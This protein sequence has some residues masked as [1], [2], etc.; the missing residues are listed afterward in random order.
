MPSHLA[1]AAVHSVP[2][3]VMLLLSNAWPYHPG[4][5]HY[6]PMDWL[7]LSLTSAT[8]KS[9]SPSCTLTGLAHKPTA[10]WPSPLRF[11][12]LLLWS[13]HLPKALRQRARGVT[14]AALALKVGT[15]LLFCCAA[16]KGLWQQQFNN[17]LGVQ[18][19]HGVKKVSLQ[20]SRAIWKVRRQSFILL[21]SIDPWRKERNMIQWKR[22]TS[23][24]RE[25]TFSYITAAN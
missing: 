24:H 4:K 8:Y 15:K 20:K 13:D 22:L 10:C 1:T 7:W 18:S 3:P 6:S 23:E 9:R 17:P 14:H 5:Q 19:R 25:K 2:R 11:A 16:W 12:H 21:P